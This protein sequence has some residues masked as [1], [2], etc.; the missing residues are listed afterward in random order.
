[1]NNL[2]LLPLNALRAIEIVGR[3]HALAPAAEELGVTVGAVSQHIRRA[4]ARLDTNLFTRTSSGLLPTPELTAVQPLLRA[5]FQA[6]SDAADMLSP[7]ED[8]VLTLTVGN[9]FASQWLVW[10]LGRFTALAPE[11]ELR[12]ITSGKLI[13]LARPDIDCGIRFGVGVWEGAEA[14]LLGGQ[15]F[16]PVCAPALAAKLKSPKDLAHVPVINDKS[17]MLSWPNW[18]AGAGVAEPPALNGPQFYDP[19]LALDAAVAGQGVLIA[20]DLIVSDAL[21]TGRLVTPFD[22]VHEAEV[23]YWFA[24][25][26]NRRR[27]EKIRRFLNWIEAEIAAPQQL[28]C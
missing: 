20:V 13:D 5:G 15:R 28:D 18:F 27:P 12:I 14:Q 3:T 1:M 25:S 2:H 26:K 23:G 22:Y 17:S 21:A 24:T 11:I 8:N 10:R 19:A 16:M 9:V 4:E 7:V 6:L